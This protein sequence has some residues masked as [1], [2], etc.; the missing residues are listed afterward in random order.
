ML[1][2]RANDG[3]VSQEGIYVSFAPTLDDP[4]AWS[5]PQRLIAGGRWYP[6]VPDYSVAMILRASAAAA[7]WRFNVNARSS[8][9]RART[10]SPACDKATP[11]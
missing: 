1:F 4:D 10:F 7:G 9:R 11:R 6:Q 2:N 3:S 5:T 8:A